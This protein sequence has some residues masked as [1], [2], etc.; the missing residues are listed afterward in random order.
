MFQ[1]R[2]NLILA[3]VEVQ[4]GGQYDTL[5]GAID[6]EKIGDGPASII[7]KSAIHSALGWCVGADQV[8]NL[9]VQDNVIYD[10]EKFNIKVSNSNNY[11]L[12]SNL[13]LG[14]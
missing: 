8:N 3:G 1:R 4:H 10:C 13:L 6:L 2:G 5:N 11:N 14:N 9:V 7:R 12:I